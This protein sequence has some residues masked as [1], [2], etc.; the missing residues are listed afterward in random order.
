MAIVDENVERVRETADALIKK[1]GG[2]DGYVRYLQ[3]RDRRRRREE[4]KRRAR[5][6]EDNKPRLQKVRSK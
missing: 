6:T 2:L 1:Y 4:S 5:H 3:S